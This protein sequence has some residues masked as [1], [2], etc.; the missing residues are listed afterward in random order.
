MVKPILKWV[1]G[2]TQILEDVLKEFPRDMNNYREIFLGGGSVLLG[3]LEHP[4]IKIR[5]KVYAYD[6]NEALV[7]VYKNIQS[8]HEELYKE[9][10]T[11]GNVNEETYYKLRKEYNA[12][13]DKKT[14]K[15]SA[16]FIV[17]NKTC[18][19]GVFRIGPNG[20]NV[21]FGH[22]KNPEI[23]N[24]E[25]L[26]KVSRLV[27]NVTFECLDFKES[28]SNISDTGDFVYLDP[29]YVPE[30]ES[31]FVSYNADGFGLDA[32]KALFAAMRATRAHVLMS[33]ADVPLIRSELT[34]PPFVVET[35]SARRAINSKEPD[36]VTQEVLVRNYVV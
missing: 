1:G 2:K 12:L 36:A 14:V 35:L 29:P 8:S 4:E 32:H 33:N 24:K 27:Q 13:D 21:P 25:H 19:R 16:L 26:E 22:Y 9:I 10:Q 30:K 6:S 34:T 23:I 18:F 20:F 17:L 5:G 3:V 7:S 28:L 11:I 31:S 15:A